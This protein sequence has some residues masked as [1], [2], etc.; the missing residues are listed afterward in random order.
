MYDLLLIVRGNY[1]NSRW[2]SSPS[3]RSP[4]LLFQC[5][6]GVSYKNRDQVGALNIMRCLQAGEHRPNSLSRNL[7]TITKPSPFVLGRQGKT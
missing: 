7:C 2:S 5:M 1:S 6:F 3:K 4:T